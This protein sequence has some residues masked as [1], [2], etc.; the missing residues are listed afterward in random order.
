VT[1]RRQL[2]IAVAAIASTP[3]TAR[4]Q[5]ARSL[6]RLGI[7]H[8]G[9]VE[10]SAV[11]KALVS[12][13]ADRGYVDGKSIVLEL[14]SG[15]GKPEMLPALAA[16]LVRSNVDVLLVVGPAAVKAA[17][18]ATRTTPI[19][20][21]DLESDPVQ[22][23]WMKSL[24][25]P[26]GNV[27]GL[28][29][30]LTAMSAKWLQ[31]LREAVPGALRISL[32]WDTTSGRSQLAATRA[33]AS[34]LSVEVQT[35]AIENWSDFDAAVNAAVRARTQAFV[36][37]SSP[38]AFQYSARLAEF[39]LRNRIPAISPFRPFVVA[40]GLM[41]Y[42]PDLDLFF[43]RTAFTIERIL[44]GAKASD[45]AAEQPTKYELAINL[46]T[47]KALGLA[48]PAPLLLRADEVIQ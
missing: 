17:M 18:A 42:G 22:N 34:S 12:G 31:L 10:A 15:N 39:T 28:F 16:G 43:Q 14:R 23:G 33:A 32:L 26:G 48:I 44:T 37:L 7:L 36:V 5:P 25:R 2:L 8:P 24:S 46:K 9:S 35:V 1:T 45:V 47:A 29:L 41:S 11:Y 19:V 27:T 21:I 6:S 40:G 38:T 4:A 13:L 20:A 3:F 30:D